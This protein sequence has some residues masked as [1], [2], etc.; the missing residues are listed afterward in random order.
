MNA[1]WL[2]EAT[3][4]LVQRSTSIPCVDIVPVRMVDGQREIGLIRRTFPGTDRSVWCQLGGRIEYLE[5][6]RNALLRH[7]AQT[8][9]GVTVALP[10]DPQPDY[11]MQWFPSPHLDNYG[12]DPRKHAIALSFVLQVE[13]NGEVVPAGEAKQFSWVKA[14]HLRG[15]RGQAWP[16]TFLLLQRLQLVI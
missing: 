16:G 14:Q 11:V 2:D 15:I 9:I 7:L 1:G 10:S 5:T 12:E 13:T 4:E 3:W 8:L 6:V